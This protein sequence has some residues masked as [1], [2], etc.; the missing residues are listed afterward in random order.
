[1]L[2]ICKSED[3][4]QFTR[5][6]WLEVG[7]GEQAIWAPPVCFHHSLLRFAKD[8]L[9]VADSFKALFLAVSQQ[10]DC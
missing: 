5:I 2:L 6:L 7:Q 10:Q 8:W 4:D 1:M 3:S 9:A